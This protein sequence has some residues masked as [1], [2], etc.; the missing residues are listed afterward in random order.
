MQRIFVYSSG[1]FGAN[2]VAAS[3]LC[4]DNAHMTSLATLG[5]RMTLLAVFS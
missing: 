5:P 4:P 3:V 2:V 1:P